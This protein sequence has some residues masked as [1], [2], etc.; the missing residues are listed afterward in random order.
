VTVYP[1]SGTTTRTHDVMSDLATKAAALQLGQTLLRAASR[2]EE[3][4]SALGV[5]LLLLDAL[6]CLH[7]CRDLQSDDADTSWTSYASELVRLP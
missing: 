7:E 3:D 2:S 4:A 6:S 1:L 5:Y